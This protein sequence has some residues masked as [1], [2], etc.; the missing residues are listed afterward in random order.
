MLPGSPYTVSTVG[1][2][3]YDQS[4]G[5]VTD[6]AID[7]YGVL[8][9]VTFNDLFVCDPTTA[10]CVY[11]ADLPQ[12]FNGLTLVPPGVLDPLLDTLVGIASSGEWYELSVGGGNVSITSIGTYGAGY[13]SSGDAFSIQGVG[14][15][16]AVNKTGVAD[17][18][19]AAVD[20]STG[21]VIADVAT[22]TG[23]S[24]IFGLAG[25]TDAVFA[26][27]SNGDV[28]FVDPTTGTW[29]VVQSTSNSW[30]GAGVYTILAQ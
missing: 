5:S 3:T 18:V 11:L 19:I 13:S 24:S 8:Y 20:P 22:L 23:Y 15:Y 27:S 12:S 7:R 4:P 2:F 10:A 28:L 1:N 6:I 14:T 25:W 30:W 26:F 17:D 29:S 16:G 21:A 9:A